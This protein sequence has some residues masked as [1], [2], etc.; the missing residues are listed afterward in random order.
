M[1]TVSVQLLGGFRVTV[2]G[3]SVA[4]D[5][6]RHRRSAAHLV[7]VLALAPGRRLHRERVLGTLWPELDPADAAPRLHKAAHY[8]RRWLAAPGALVLDGETVALCPADEVAV[9]AV[10]FEERARAALAARDP[11][12]ASAAADLYGGELL[13]DDPYEPWTEEP[14]ER[15]RQ[16]HL[17]A[18]RLAGRW[19]EVVGLEPA[20][21]RAHVAL[22]RRLAEDGDR[23][24]ALRQF[25]RLER[26]LRTELGVDLSPEAARLR[27]SLLAAQ[28]SSSAPEL[29]GRDDELAWVRGVLGRVR[30]GTGRTVFV[31]GPAGVGKTSLLAALE[32][33]AVG[34]GMRV[35]TGLAARIDGAWPYAPVL[36]A[37]ADLSRRHPALL[38]GLDDAMRREIERALSGRDGGW[39]GQGGHQRLFIAAGELLRLAAAGTGAVLVVDDAHEADQASLRLLHFLGRATLGDRVAVVLGHR[40]VSGGVLAEVRGAVLGRGSAATLDLR[41]LRPPDALAL[42]RRHAPSAPLPALQAV[43][44]AARGLPFG[45]VE[46][47]RAVAADPTAPPGAALLPRLPEPVLRAIA[48]AAVLGASFDTDEFVALSGLSDDEAYSVLDA[49]VAGG[50]LRRTATGF[51]FGHAL[52]REGLL[53]R[54]TG[55]GGRR[56]AHR[57]AARALQL[58]GRSPGRIG[59]HLVQAG[60]VDRAVPWVLRAAETEAA[61]GAYRDAL[62]TLD[63]VRTA[64]AGE[65]AGRLLALRADLLASCGDL[66]TFEAFREAL[67]GITDPALRAQ[68]RI[69]LAQTAVQHGD[70]ETSALALDGLA[71]DGSRTDTELLVA[72]GSV[73]LFRG[74][75]AAAADA[76]D[77]ARRRILLDS[78]VGGRLFDLVTL[79]GLLAHYRGEW[80]QQLR[81]ELRT[82]ADRPE[83]AS[84]LFDSHLCVAEFLLYGPTPYEEVLALAAQLRRTAERAGVLRGVAFARALSG[85]AALLKGDLDLAEEELAGSADL[86]RSLESPAGEAVS[87]QR[88]AEVHVQRGDP[89]QARQLLHR[90]LLLARW[91]MVARCLMPRIYGTMIAAAVDEPAAVAV[92]EQAEAALAPEDYCPFCSIMLAVPAARASAAAG[93]LERARRWLARAETVAGRWS[94]TSWDAALVEVRAGLARAEGRPIEAGRLYASAAALFDSSGQPVDAARCRDALTPAR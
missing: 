64:V 67:A 14:R 59:H 66:A 58:L 55:A 50:L 3:R 24:A 78:P 46:G 93:E 18:L 77:E 86:H 69:R 68:V 62:A 16:L 2:G 1:R 8:A 85:E 53:A 65:D 44:V 25:E 80:F 90:S 51:A 34:A 30:Q 94:G 27:A 28:P 60:E 89:D 72:R 84:R 81:A 45:V 36:E 13:P 74:E 75:L 87:L 47:A 40:P 23:P 17:D 91:S 32:A 26:A 83:L 56:D 38:D 49:A 5:E 39:D 21:E 31:A 41:P 29:L 57:A 54:W 52:Q 20:D 71:T 79:Q 9:D 73:A 37:L 82:G 15:L 92:V 7:Q 6:W 11:G 48:P 88:L 61:L 19:S 70:L 33:T 43:T 42:A 12:P 22:A 63:Q 4:D 76:A 10:V 35:G